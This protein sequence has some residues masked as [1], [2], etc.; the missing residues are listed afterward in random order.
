MEHSGLSVPSVGRKPTLQTV[1]AVP[2]QHK[3]GEITFLVASGCCCRWGSV[4]TSHRVKVKERE[5]DK[6][7]TEE[8]I[9]HLEG[10]H[11]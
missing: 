2:L 4:S 3:A 9:K 1:A 5:R 10:P 8:K 11:C 6:V 7:G